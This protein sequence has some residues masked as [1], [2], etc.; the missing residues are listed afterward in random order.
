MTALKLNEI[1]MFKTD[2]TLAS[3]ANVLQ[4][5]NE[6]LLQASIDGIIDCSSNDINNYLRQIG[7][8]KSNELESNFHHF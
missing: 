4:A 8:S 2:K 5:N 1:L 3:Q 7:L 6:Q